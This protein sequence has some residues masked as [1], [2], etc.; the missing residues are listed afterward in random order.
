MQQ[1]V[2]LNY[3]EKEKKRMVHIEHEKNSTATTQHQ[4]SNMNITIWI[5]V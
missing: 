5:G 2:P 4:L 3:F 1:D